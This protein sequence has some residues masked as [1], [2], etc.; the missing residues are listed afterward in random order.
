MLDFT[1]L[2]NWL[3][4]TG[5][6]EK[7]QTEEIKSSERR[8]FQRLNLNDCRVFIGSEG[9]FPVL[10]LSFGGIRIDLESYSGQFQ[11]N[12]ELYCDVFLENI[13]LS[14]SVVVKNIAGRLAGCSFSNL[15]INESR[16]LRDFLKPRILGCSLR[17]IES[18][19]LQNDA[20]ELRL[21]WFQ[22]EDGT[23]IF[24]WQTMDGESVKQEFY[25]FDYFIG[26]EKP[27][28][29]LKIG[30]IKDAARRNFGRISPESIAFFKIPSHRALRL[31]QTILKFSQ[32]PLE[33]TERL[34]NEIAK[35]EKRLYHRYVI[36]EKE[37][38]F[39]PV[40]ISELNVPVLNL[41]SN[42]IAIL[43][44]P[45]LS[46]EKG[47]KISGILQLET[48]ELKV[49][50]T[51]AFI[52][53]HFCGG[54]LEMS[55]SDHLIFSGFLAPRL[56]AQYLEKVPA[57][58]EVPFFATTDSHSYLYAGLHNTHI[59]SLIDQEG[60]LLAGRI[61]FMDILIRY[62]N[63]KL[64]QHSCTE[65]I[66]FPGDWDIPAHLLK[67]ESPM[68]EDATNFCIELLGSSMMPA[69][70]KS[71]WLGILKATRK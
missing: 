22:G 21:R 50:F 68:S 35:E 69:E 57:P 30:I 53:T 32:L 65:G 43:N 4:G 59:L 61:A 1:K 40:A 47:Q 7:Y 54:S 25:F 11:Q 45:E 24:L 15:S 44:I 37:I 23:Q 20:P 41:S 2:I 31:G 36:R 66:I 49:D 10:N 62:H 46:I 26:W 39:S 63:R 3:S 42:G 9:P 51:P 16:I 67:G 70:I 71:A 60:N 13:L 28:T 17:E 19:K 8:R 52:E 29:S 34:I 56:L 55:P 12:T 64:L 48:D 14:N 6:N 58:L 27:D 18:A 38:Y 33:A 5:D